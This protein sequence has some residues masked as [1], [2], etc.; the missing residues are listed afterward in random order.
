MHDLVLGI[1]LVEET[2]L[3]GTRFLT[4]VKEQLLK[5]DD[6][7]RPLVHLAV[8]SGDTRTFK[9]VVCAF[10]ALDLGDTE[11]GT[12]LMWRTVLHNTGRCLW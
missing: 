1:L 11:V 9:A 5:V 12:S 10:L 2:Q 6:H 3:S 7:R 8:R 4:Q